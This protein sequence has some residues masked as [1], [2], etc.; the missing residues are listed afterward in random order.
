[1]NVYSTLFISTIYTIADF[2][3][4]MCISIISGLALGFLIGTLKLRLIYG[5]FLSLKS[6]PMTIFIPI[7][8]RIFGVGDFILP[9]VAT[10][11][12]I[13]IAVNVCEAIFRSDEIRTLQ[14]KAMGISFLDYTK[15]ILFW[16]ILEVIIATIR[17]S[18][19]SAMAL[20]IAL[21]YFLQA[22][23]GVGAELSSSASF[24]STWRTL[25]FA[26]P[27]SLFTVACV[28]LLDRQAARLLAWKKR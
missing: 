14:R 16:E 11:S 1:M 10:P 19:P 8:I 18:I 23:S 3:V 5:L 28:W 27:I 7:Y 15:H 2:F 9:L 6:I 20:L 17:V 24:Y 4:I 25:I 26:L 12:I 13:I 22:R 21:D